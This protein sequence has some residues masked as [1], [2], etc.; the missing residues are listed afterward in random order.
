M[1]TC[2]HHVR[3]FV[4][5]SVTAQGLTISAEEDGAD[6]DCCNMGSPTAASAPAARLAG[7]LGSNPS[8]QDTVSCAAKPARHT[9]DQ[10]IAQVAYQ[11]RGTADT[12]RRYLRDAGSLQLLLMRPAALPTLQVDVFASGSAGQ[13]PRSCWPMGDDEVPVGRV[14][15]PLTV[16]AEAGADEGAQMRI[17]CDLAH[18]SAS[19]PDTGRGTPGT[20]RDPLE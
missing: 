11:L 8:S 5:P 15:V 19:A 9:P 2:A 3:G 4:I 13:L 1:I 17:P 10:R 6:S 12:L 18:A 16:L 20:S 7:P 14:A